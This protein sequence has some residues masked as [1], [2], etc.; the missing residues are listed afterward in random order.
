MFINA[1]PK[2]VGCQF[3]SDE[4][5]AVGRKKSNGRNRQ[6]GTKPYFFQMANSIPNVILSFFSNGQFLG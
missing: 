6:F 1:D 2:T 3:I 4:H 5:F